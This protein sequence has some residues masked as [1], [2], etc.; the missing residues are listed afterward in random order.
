MCKAKSNTA[1]GLSKQSCKLY[2]DQGLSDCSTH[3]PMHMAVTFLMTCCSVG[4]LSCH[5]QVALAVFGGIGC[6]CCTNASAEMR[7][8][9][10]NF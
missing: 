10:Q 3:R 4:L 7:T 8:V 2:L 6:F 1:D 5:I 9:L